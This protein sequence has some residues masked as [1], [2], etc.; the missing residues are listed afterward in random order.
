MAKDHRR[1]VSRRNLLQAG[2]ALVVPSTLTPPA[3]ADG[4]NDTPPI[5]FRKPSWWWD[6]T[7][8]PVG[9]CLPISTGCK[10]CWVPK[11]LKSHTWKTETVHTGVI[12]FVRGRP[13]WNGNL[14]AY[15][16]GDHVWNWPL[17]WPGVVNPALGP[18]EPNLIFVV[19]EGD[20]F[21]TGRPKEDI[22]KVCMTIAAS[23]HI[24]ILCTKYTKEMAA[25]LSALDPRTVRKWK[26]KLWLVFSAE[27]QECFD[28][29]W[30]DL[31][32]FAE[33]GWFV[34]VSISP[35]L[36]PV[37]LPPDALELLRWVVVNGAC[38][39]IKPELCRPMEADWARAVRDQCRPAGIAFFMRA[40]HSGAYV[41]PD[42]WIREFPSV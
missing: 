37:T 19:L 16:D 14:T 40:M 15:E 23:Q 18:G 5:D 30:P 17:T 38:E 31:R 21:V 36:G 25:Y 10:N 42:L 11:W 34:G 3:L 8:T 33:A 39:Q 35:M 6:W 22:D 41:P 2:A 1:D 7:W 20:L 32:P 9:G 12:K 29:R 26:S 24:G 13:V 27:D 28:Q 4:M